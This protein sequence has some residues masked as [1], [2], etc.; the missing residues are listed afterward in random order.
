V[1]A[2]TYPVFALTPRCGMAQILTANTNRDGTGTLGTV[3]A[4]GGNGTRIDL[5]TI[6][7]IVTTTAGMIRLFIHDGTNYRLWKEVAVSAITPS[8]TV[9]AFAGILTPDTDGD[10]PLILPA[11]YSLRASTNNAETFNVIAQGGDF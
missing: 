10:L 11:N 3:L 2:N 6:K 8:G 7:A 4:A 9:A 5:I 1:T